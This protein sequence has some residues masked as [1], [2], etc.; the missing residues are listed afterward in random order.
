MIRFVFV[1]RDW[2]TMVATVTVSKLAK[3]RSWKRVYHLKNESDSARNLARL[4]GKHG[5][6]IYSDT[7]FEPKQH[8]WGVEVEKRGDSDFRKRW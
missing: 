8:E 5:T 4:L 2:E 3:G 6:K 7:C 1:D